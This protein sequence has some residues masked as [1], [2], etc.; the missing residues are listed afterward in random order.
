MRELLVQMSNA[1]KKEPASIGPGSLTSIAGALLVLHIKSYP[2][3]LY[4]E[5]THRSMHT[6]QRYKMASC[7]SLILW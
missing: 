4:G 2:L 6:T 3:F 1:V 5:I 7:R